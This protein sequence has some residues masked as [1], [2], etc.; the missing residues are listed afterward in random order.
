VI[1][2]R[3]AE[4]VNVRLEI[5]RERFELLRE[6]RRNKSAPPPR[7][8]HHR[9]EPPPWRP[10]PLQAPRALKRPNPAAPQFHLRLP[11][12][13][14]TRP[15]SARSLP[16]VEENAPA[17][18]TQ[19][20]ASAPTVAAQSAAPRPAPATHANPVAPKD[21][22]VFPDRRPGGPPATPPRG[23]HLDYFDLPRPAWAK[24]L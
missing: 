19:P 9:R 24:P 10:P 4:L 18:S 3:R 7:P 22:P 11:A 5:E 17:T 14:P 6:K 15:A 16:A 23:I 20:T 1:A 13:S 12:T 2:L 8:S 21:V